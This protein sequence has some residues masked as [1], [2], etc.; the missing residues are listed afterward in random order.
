MLHGLILWGILAVAVPRLR[1]GG[2]FVLAVGAECAWEIFE[3]SA[4]II[5]RYRAATAA[6]GYQGDTVANSMGDILSGAVGFWLASRLG[7]WK[8]LALFLAIE[9]LLLVWIRDSLVLNVVMLIRPLRSV[10]AWQTGGQGRPPNPALQRTGGPVY[11]F[12]LGGFYR[13]PAAEL[14][15]RRRRM[16]VYGGVHVSI[17]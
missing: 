16:V 6:Q 4:F 7:W 1:L 15:V 2:R 3:N 14:C 11:R 5:D 10:R 8:S 12:E 9:V 17:H 13:P